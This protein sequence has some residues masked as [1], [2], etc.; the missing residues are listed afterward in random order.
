[1]LKEGLFFS[2]FSSPQ[3]AT[4]AYTVVEK[5]EAGKTGSMQGVAPENPGRLGPKAELNSN[6]SPVRAQKNGCLC[7]QA[8]SRPT[9]AGCLLQGAANRQ[10]T[11]PACQGR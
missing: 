3:L 5:P 10:I 1:M 8:G 7:A 11:V 2:S 9:L 4:S 6:P